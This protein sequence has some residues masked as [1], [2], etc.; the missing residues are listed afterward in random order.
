MVESAAPFATR[1]SIPPS[2]C[3]LSQLQHGIEELFVPTIWKMNSNKSCRPAARCKWMTFCRRTMQVST[4]AVM[5][6][7]MIY[8]FVDLRHIFLRYNIL[9][10]S[11][12]RH[13]ATCGGDTGTSSENNPRTTPKDTSCSAA[14]KPS[15]QPG[16]CECKCKPSSTTTASLSWHNDDKWQNCTAQ[17]QGGVLIAIAKCKFCFNAY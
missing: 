3:V 17:D 1:P 5:A 6:I 14:V 15:Q 16:S 13:K 8:F 12:N 10:S 11:P 9:F 4:R 7:R 2:W